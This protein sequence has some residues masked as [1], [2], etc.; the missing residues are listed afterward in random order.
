MV[1]NFTQS[2]AQENRWPAGN[3]S[4]FAPL[5]DDAQDPLATHADADMIYT[6][7]RLTEAYEDDEFEVT[8]DFE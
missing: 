1:W 3:L 7:K 8:N 6:S 2:R 5:S 4:G